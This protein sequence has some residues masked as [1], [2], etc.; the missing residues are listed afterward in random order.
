LSALISFE[1]ADFLNSSLALFFMMCIMC[2]KGE[3]YLHAFIALVV[4]SL[5]CDIFWVAATIPMP[6]EEVSDTN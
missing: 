6:E 3:S 2:K 5:M 1:R 4:F